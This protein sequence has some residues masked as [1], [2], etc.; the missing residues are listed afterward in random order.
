MSHNDERD[1]W[2]SSLPPDERMAYLADL[3]GGYRERL[4]R[5]Y[6]W[7]LHVAERMTAEGLVVRVPKLD[8]PPWF[9][10][11]VG[12]EGDVLVSRAGREV[13]IEVK[14][15]AL[16]FSEGG[17]DFPFRTAIVTTLE[18]WNNKVPPARAF[19]FVSQITHAMASL[20]CRHRVSWSVI[21]L[22]E[23]KRKHTQEYLACP[24]EQLRPFMDLVRALRSRP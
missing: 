3:H 24:R 16:R 23:P 1:K 12:D 22:C 9:K 4:Q 17:A 5:G 20:S 2:L 18:D 10:A 19:V 15:R 8:L 7:Q 14:S 21:T 11:N 13:R 6:D